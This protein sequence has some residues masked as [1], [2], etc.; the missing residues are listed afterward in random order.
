MPTFRSQSL[1]SQLDR[2]TTQL[3][4]AER[5][6]RPLGS[7]SGQGST[8]TLSSLFETAAK[9]VGHSSNLIPVSHFDTVIPSYFPSPWHL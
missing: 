6:C 4:R 8:K 2:K 7:Q 5:S 9:F 1:P 3:T